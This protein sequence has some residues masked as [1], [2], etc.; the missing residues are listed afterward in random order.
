VRATDGN[1]GRR[2]ASNSA[3]R[4]KGL[5]EPAR[6]QSG[7]DP[8]VAQFRSLSTDQSGNFNAPDIVF[9]DPKKIKK[10]PE[11]FLEKRGQTIVMKTH[12]LKKAMEWIS[13]SVGI[14]AQPEWIS[15]YDP[16]TQK[17]LMGFINAERRRQR[18]RSRRGSH[19]PKPKQTPRSTIK[20]NDTPTDAQEFAY[21]GCHKIYLLES[22]DDRNESIALG[23]KILP[24]SALKDTFENSC[25]LRFVSNWMLTIHPVSQFEDAHFEMLQLSE[26][27]FGC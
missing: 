1:F 3:R 25:E 23:Y 13:T 4:A 9:A 11:T 8:P 7:S 5:L 20:I 19:P 2:R 27:N 26:S 10:S 21:D 16:N 17:A 18:L 6:Y 12:L 24:V 22:E 14:D 15:A